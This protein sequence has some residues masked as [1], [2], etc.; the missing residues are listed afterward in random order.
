MHKKWSSDAY[1]KSG[2]NEMINFE[3]MTSE[4]E[5]ERYANTWK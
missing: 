4:R 2:L 3:S 5:K 1:P